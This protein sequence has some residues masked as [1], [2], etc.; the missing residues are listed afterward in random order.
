MMN[1]LLRQNLIVTLLLG[2]NLA[3]ASTALADDPSGGYFDGIEIQC[4]NTQGGSGT[5]ASESA[6]YQEALQNAEYE[7]NEVYQGLMQ[8][9]DE[10]EKDYLQ[11]MQSA[12][13]TL[14]ESQ[15]SLIHYY[16]RDARLNDRFKLHCQAAMTIR[17]VQE[18]KQL[19]TGISWSKKTL[20]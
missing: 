2:A 10:Q 19:G 6:C 13:I 5:T 14:K 4:P 16:Y 12:W 18:L 1:K 3:I 8:Q 15:C 20:P 17:R 7:L 9:A 11:K